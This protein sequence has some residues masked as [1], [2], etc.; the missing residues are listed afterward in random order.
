MICYQAKLH[1]DETGYWAEFPDLPGC[2]TQGKTKEQVL[3]R[4]REALGA[5]LEGEREDTWQVPPPKNRKGKNYVWV[6]P[7]ED[8]AIPLMIRQA[9]LSRGLSQRQFAKMLKMTVQQLQKLETP[10]KSNPT[11]RTLAAIAEALDGDFKLE[12]VA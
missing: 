6:R 10:G 5:W 9:R 8:V 3:L 12:L 7:H 1:R 2:F 4:A 11:V